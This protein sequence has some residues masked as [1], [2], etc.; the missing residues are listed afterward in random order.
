MEA[1]L[2]VLSRLKYPK[3]FLL[4]LSYVI[5]FI[6]FVDRSY[7]PL[8]DT[9]V[10]FGYFGTCLAGF[11]YAY[12]FTAAPAAAILLI[13]AREQKL[14]FA[15]LIAGFGALLSDLII[16]HFVRSSF[17]GELQKLSEEKVVK[18]A[19][20]MVPGSIQK[21]LLVS[22][23]CFFIASPLP[24]EIGVTLLA[25]IKNVTPKKFSIMA[26]VLHTAA[27]FAILLIG[28]AI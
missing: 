18:V 11:L 12:S 2:K 16:F 24:T 26:Y 3:L 9:L 8:H 20:R 4:F 5:A 13:L 10:F 22:L 14:F 19:Q 28:N 21:Y 23:A 27:I 15:G 6:L 1:W 25:S 7:A 17:S